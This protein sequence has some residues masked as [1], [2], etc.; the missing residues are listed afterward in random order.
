MCIMGRA[1]PVADNQAGAAPSWRRG[2]FD[3]LFLRQVFATAA[4]AVFLTYFPQLKI[5]K[6]CPG[7]V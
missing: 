7:V 4:A 5:S 2:N 6:S 3:M 1:S